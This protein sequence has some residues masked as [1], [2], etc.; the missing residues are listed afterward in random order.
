M[1]AF[2]HSFNKYFLTINICQTCARHKDTISPSFRIKQRQ[3][4]IWSVKE[5]NPDI[6]VNGGN[7]IERREKERYLNCEL[8]A[9]KRLDIG[10]AKEEVLNREIVR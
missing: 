8:M 7:F 9:R 10:S 5:I 3:V 4:I 1:S 6:K 2:V